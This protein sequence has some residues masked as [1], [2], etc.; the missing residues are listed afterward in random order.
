VE[1]PGGRLFAVAERQ[2]V[3][4]DSDLLQ[5]LDVVVERAVGDG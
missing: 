3:E 2:E 1:G 4:Q 5:R